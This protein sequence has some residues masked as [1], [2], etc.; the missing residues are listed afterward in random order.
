MGGNAEEVRRYLR[1]LAPAKTQTVI[2][3]KRVQKQPSRLHPTSWAFSQVVFFVFLFLLLSRENKWQE[4]ECQDVSRDFLNL[5]LK[6]TGLNKSPL[7]HLRGGGLLFLPPT[8]MHTGQTVSPRTHNSA[9]HQVLYEV[10]GCKSALW[11]GGGRWRSKRFRVLHRHYR[12]SE[13]RC[14]F[15]V[16]V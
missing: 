13:L 5:L 4:L 9:I 16:G 11:S 6:L 2:A 8:L 10:M 15:L 3:D 7:R 14:V 12:C 1:R